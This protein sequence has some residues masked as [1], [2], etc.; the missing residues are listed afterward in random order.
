[1]SRAPILFRV[2]GT[3][4]AGFE[5]FWRC[6]TF[7]AAL[8]RRRRPIFF[9]SNLEPKSLSFSVKRVGNS[10]LSTKNS[11]GSEDDL[12]ELIQEVRRL[13]PGAVVLD[14]QNVSREY[15]ETVQAEGVTVVSMDHIADQRFSSELVINPLLAPGKEDYEVAPYSQVLLGARYALVR[16]EVR[17]LRPLRAQ[18]P[19][20]PFRALVALGDDDPHRQSLDLAKLLVNCPQVDR[21]DLLIRAHHPDLKE[22]QNLAEANPE[23]IEIAVEAPE[24]AAKIVRCH[25]AVTAGNVTAL[26]LGC[27]GIPQLVIVQNEVHW[28][29]AQRLEEEGA[30]TCLGWHENVS[31]RT[32]RDAVQNLLEDPLER[33]S[34]SRCGRRLI[35]GRGADRMVNGLEI[36]LHHSR[37]VETKLAA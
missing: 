10:W 9:L 19:T 36:L 34:M 6:L 24:V 37:P 33:K 2:D 30:A 13:Q 17:R 15:I 20:Q 11:I 23:K 22:M 3:H 12:E 1:M 16:P 7:S 18:E 8:Q 21:V 29:T 26:E 32:I 5:S 14:S 35:D 4:T 28:P 31:E 25:F 27:V